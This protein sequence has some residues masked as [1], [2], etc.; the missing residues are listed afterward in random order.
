MGTLGMVG[1]GRMGGNMAE[2]L[3]RGGHTVV[4][5]DAAAGARDMDSL[6]ALVD[7]LP[8]PRVVWVMVPSGEPTSS[9]VESLG[10][11]LAP[12]DVV[13]DGGNSKYTED[14]IHAAHLAEKGVGFI[15]CGVSGGVWGLAEGYALMTG[16]SPENLALVQPF[17]D[18]LKPEGDHGYVHAGDVGAGHF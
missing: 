5:Y 12:G 16:G 7:A 1:L 10:K 4:G 9:T 14:R 3:R 15:D 6:E 8:A 18:T 2:R 13:V 17:L 11:L